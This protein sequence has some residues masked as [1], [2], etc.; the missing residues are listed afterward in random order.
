[1]TQKGKDKPVKK[2][3]GFKVPK[4]LR[5]GGLGAF[6][7][8]PLGRQMLADALIAAATAAAAA[9]VKHRPSAEQVAQAGERAANAGAGAVTGT[10]DAAKSVTEAVAGL[11]IDLLPASSGAEDARAADEGRGKGYDHLAERE[12]KRK[13]DKNRAKSSEH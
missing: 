9:L 11:A 13:K 5:K 1:V 8:S 4:V 6:L 10:R 3:A 2:I 12:S 7:D